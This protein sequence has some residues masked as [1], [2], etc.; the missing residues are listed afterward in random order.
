MI[1]M[2]SAGNKYLYNKKELQEELNVYDYGARFYDPVIARWGS[3]DDLAEKFD[4]TSPYVYVLNRPASLGDYDGR[5]TIMSNEI[6]IRSTRIEPAFVNPPS[7][8]YIPYHQIKPIPTIK[9]GAP[10]LP[11]PFLLFLSFMLMPQNSMSD[12]SEKD[13]LQKIWLNKIQASEK[14]VQEILEDTQD[15]HDTGTGVAIKTKHGGQDQ[16]D[17]DF[18]DLVDPS[19]VKQIPKTPRNQTNGRLGRLPD[20]TIVLVRGSKDGRPTLDIQKQ[21]PIKIRY[22]H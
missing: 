22:N 12:H 3:I 20:G 5:D 8:V 21:T 10:P 7:P 1:I 4:D 15:D 18:D 2:G 16:A 11:N 13:A 6:T 14:S 19:T 17:K 9:P